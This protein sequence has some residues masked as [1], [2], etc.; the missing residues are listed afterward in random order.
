[1][2]VGAAKEELARRRRKRINYTG[3]VSPVEAEELQ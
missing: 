1:M 2:R 3:V